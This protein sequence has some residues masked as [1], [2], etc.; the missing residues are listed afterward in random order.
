MSWISTWTGR[1]VYPLDPKPEQICLEDIAHGLAHK[2]RYNGQSKFYTVAEHSVHLSD[3][4]QE[5]GDRR[6]ALYALLHD[7]AEAY[8]P[9]VTA[10][11]KP[12]FGEFKRCEDRMLGVIFQRLGIQPIGQFNASIIKEADAR[13]CLN[14]RDV[15]LPNH[16]PEIKWPVDDLEPLDGVSIFCWPPDEALDNFMTV[17]MELTGTEGT[18]SHPFRDRGVDGDTVFC[19]SCGKSWPIEEV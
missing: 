2:C 11:I 16:R 7:A 13:I 5:H 19:A 18:C 1:Q 8:L 10:P 4:C 6:L 3:W 17:Y 15:V 12:L 9:D 14:E